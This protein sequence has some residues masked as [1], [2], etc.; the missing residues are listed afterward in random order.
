MATKVWKGFLNFGMLSIPVFLNVAAR[1]KRVE[2]NTFHTACNGRVKMP[3]WCP[4]CNVQL[5]PTET[6]RGFDTGNGIIRLTDEELEGIT[7]ASEKTMEI[8]ECVKFSEID[9]IYMA[10]SFYLLPDSA[11]AKAYYLLVKTLTDSGRV[12]IVQIS[13]NSR[14]H[15]AIIRPRGNGLMLHYIWYPAEIA[16]VPEFDRLAPAT[17]STTE[18]KLA[19]QLVE[20]MAAP[21][22]PGQFEDGYLQRLNTLIASKQDSRIAAPAPVNTTARAATVD[23]T[24][25]LMS[26]LAAKNSRSIRLPDEAAPTAPSTRGRRARGRRAA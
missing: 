17:V 7:P 21:F 2:L 18:I 15:V 8:A 25:A 3:K 19:T 4:S 24:A 1:D 14:E 23:I 12:G 9:P 13:K 20:S 5:Q 10:E 11:G 6:Y 16:E 26:S 22:N